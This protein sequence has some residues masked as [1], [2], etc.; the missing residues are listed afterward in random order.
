MILATLSTSGGGRREC[1]SVAERTDVVTELKDSI[2]WSYFLSLINDQCMYV[3]S[4]IAS[5]PAP[6]STRFTCLYSAVLRAQGSSY[7]L[8]KLGELQHYT[9]DACRGRTCAKLKTCQDLLCYP[10]TCAR[11]PS[12][13]GDCI[14]ASSCA[15]SLEVAT[16]ILRVYMQLHNGTPSG[17]VQ[18]C[19][20]WTPRSIAPLRI[21]EFPAT[22]RLR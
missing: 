16:T 17:S 20:S 22:R 7:I 2:Q 21:A 9:E 13:F 8:A 18:Q 11:R 1:H 14:A 15:P 12:I 4:C 3:T 10:C 19:V 5:S 6:S